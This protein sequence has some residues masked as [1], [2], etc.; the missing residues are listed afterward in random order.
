MQ[1]EA[2]HVPKYDLHLNPEEL[3]Q[4]QTLDFISTLTIKLNQVK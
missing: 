1:D 4:M 3:Q 2:E